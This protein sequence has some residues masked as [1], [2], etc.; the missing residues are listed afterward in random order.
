MNHIRIDQKLI[1]P[2]FN[3]EFG[4]T[5]QMSL[6]SDEFVDAL[7]A[8]ILPE[9]VQVVPS[10]GRLTLQKGNEPI[11]TPIPAPRTTV[12]FFPW[13]T[14]PH[15]RGHVGS[16]VP[17]QRLP[18]DFDLFDNLGPIAFR[19]GSGGLGGF[20]TVTTAHTK[21]RAKSRLVVEFD[22][23]C[24]ENI[25]TMMDSSN[26][27]EPTFT[28]SLL[29]GLRLLSGNEPHQHKGFRVNDGRF[30][31]LI[32]KWPLTE[33][34]GVPVKIG[35]AD[36]EALKGIFLQ[37][38]QIRRDA[39]RDPE[40]NKSSAILNLALDNYYLSSTIGE[41]RTAFLLLMI[42]V[43]TLF[44]DRDEESASAASSRLAKLVAQTKAEYNE[45][46]RFMWDTNGDAACCQVRN[47]IVHGDMKGLRCNMYWRLKAYIR[48]AIVKIVSLVLSSGIDREKYYESMNDY[49]NKNLASL[50]N[51]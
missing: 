9:P 10:H 11:P 4:K 16:L 39:R 35:P 28:E 46:R 32:V 51:S 33:V 19:P 29:D 22:Q 7:T 2:L 13:D 27:Y 3:A 21:L 43:E 41:L 1:V 26:P 44:K 50:P 30:V 48:V 36:V 38:W 17:L 49:A 24:P 45:I 40:K 31:D 12:Y 42:A 6:T 37:I 20:Q 8:F 14:D 47:Q 5:L 23:A 34:Q 18:A 25:R 15:S